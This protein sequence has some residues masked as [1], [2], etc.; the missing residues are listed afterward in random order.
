MFKPS[1]RRSDRTTSTLITKPNEHQQPHAPTLSSSSKLSDLFFPRNQM[2]LGHQGS[3][4]A[5]HRYAV[6]ESTLGQSVISLQLD[7]VQAEFPIKERAEHE[8]R[9]PPKL[10]RQRLE[11]SL[12]KRHD[13]LIVLFASLLDVYCFELDDI[14]SPESC[15]AQAVGNSTNDGMSVIEIK[16]LKHWCL[17]LV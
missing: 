9:G 16:R 10:K 13:V 8:Q 17:S 15:F 7:H 14:F 2:R 11:R 12:P 6:D 5:N 3:S 1:F 4:I